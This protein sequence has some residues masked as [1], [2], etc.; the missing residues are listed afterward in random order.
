MCMYSGQT[1]CNVNCAYVG[2]TDADELQLCVSNK[3]AAHSCI[4][5]DTG[6]Y[7]FAALQGLCW[8]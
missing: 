4:K 8:F 6:Y 5:R 1:G 3:D 7:R 2:P